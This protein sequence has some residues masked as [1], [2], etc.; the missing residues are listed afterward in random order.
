MVNNLGVVN[1]AEQRDCLVL[2]LIVSHR[3]EKGEN[4]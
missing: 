4:I 1:N 2:V 3:T